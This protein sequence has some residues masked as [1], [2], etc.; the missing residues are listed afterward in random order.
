V[1]TNTATNTDTSRNRLVLS[2]AILVLAAAILAGCGKKGD[3][4]APDSNSTYPE[5]YPAE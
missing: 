1:N 2:I 4:E 3:P 5:T